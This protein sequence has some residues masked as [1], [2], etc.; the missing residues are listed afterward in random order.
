[1]AIDIE[2][3]CNLIQAK[4]RDN[5]APTLI[6]NAPDADAYLPSLHDAQC[7]YVMTWPG[8]GSFYQKGGGYK[9]DQRTFEVFCFVQAQGQQEIPTRTVDGIRI[10]QAMRNLFITAHNIPLAD[11]DVTGYQIT[12]ESDSATPHSD[13]GLIGS[14]PYGG[15]VFMGF[16]LRL[17]VR[18]YWIVNP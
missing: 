3:A 8:E 5:L 1:M 7:P 11:I 15:L 17:N 9:I 12:V 16:T 14:L 2:L 4:I 18:T 10:L 13:T 6:Q